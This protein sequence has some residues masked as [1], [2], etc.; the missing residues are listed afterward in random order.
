MHQYYMLLKLNS[1]SKEGDRA[2]FLEP[3]VKQY[4]KGVLAMVPTTGKNILLVT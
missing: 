3:G 4:I 1:H 2:V